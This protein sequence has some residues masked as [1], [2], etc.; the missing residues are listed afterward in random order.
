MCWGNFLVFSEKAFGDVLEGP[1]STD[2][3][4]VF[5][6]SSKDHRTPTCLEAVG[7]LCDGSS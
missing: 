6:R 1:R 5:T 2:T 7:L 3:L 4:S